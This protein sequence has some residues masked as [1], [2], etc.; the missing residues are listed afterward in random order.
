VSGRTAITSR[1]MISAAF[2]SFRPR[3]V[4]VWIMA[5]WRR[6]LTHW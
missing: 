1:V 6:G 3:A 5:M 4:G 2:N